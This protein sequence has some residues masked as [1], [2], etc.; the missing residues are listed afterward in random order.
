MLDVISP[1]LIIV[2][3]LM[4]DMDGPTLISHIRERAETKETPILLLSP[5]GD[6]SAVMK[7]IDSGAN[8]Y[9]PKPVLHHDLVGKVRQMLERGA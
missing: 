2:D 1:V 4:P 7:G 3:S 9:L 8:D 5:R 6:A